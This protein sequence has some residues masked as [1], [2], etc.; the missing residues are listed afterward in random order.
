MESTEPLPGYK[1]S[2]SFSILSLY[3]NL[4]VKTKSSNHLAF[5]LLPFVPNRF[6][7]KRKTMIESTGLVL[8][9]VVKF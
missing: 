1:E 2:D 5:W 6:V 9:Y 7:I 3:L 4:G 8:E